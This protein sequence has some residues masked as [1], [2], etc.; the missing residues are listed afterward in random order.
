VGITIAMPWLLKALFVV[1]K[2]RRGRKLLLA[3]G[4]AAMELAQGEQAQ[5]LYAKA[6]TIVHDETVRQKVGRRARKVRQTIR[7]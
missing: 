6:R 7:P 5:K 3:T 4:L 1:I 2:T